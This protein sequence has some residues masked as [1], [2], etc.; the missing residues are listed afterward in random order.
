MK[1]F[2]VFF[3]H[4]QYGYYSTTLEDFGTI[5]EALSYFI[6]N[7]SFVEIYGIMTTY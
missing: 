7:Y 4:T 6:N 2:T 3:E 5:D 1:K